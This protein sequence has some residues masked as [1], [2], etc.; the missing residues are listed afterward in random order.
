MGLLRREIWKKI[1]IGENEEFCALESSATKFTIARRTPNLLR[2]VK[3]RTVPFT[4]RP[5]C[6]QRRVN[7]VLR[8]EYF[9]ALPNFPTSESIR[10][11]ST[12]HSHRRQ[13]SSFPCAP[14]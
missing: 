7:V 2:P 6:K 13:K 9:C 1:L 5:L 8:K 4:A 10:P 14:H 11:Y 3:V 12:Q